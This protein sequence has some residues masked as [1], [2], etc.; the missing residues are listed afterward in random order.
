MIDGMA[1]L[2]NMVEKNL[3]SP[4]FLVGLID[5]WPGLA[6]LAKLDGRVIAASRKWEAATGVSKDEL[7][8]YGWKHFVLAEDQGKV[9]EFSTELAMGNPP[10]QSFCYR[11][12]HKGKVYAL[13]WNSTVAVGADQDVTF[14]TAELVSVDNIPTT[15]SE[16]TTQPSL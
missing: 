11:W 16:G 12:V 13:R 15:S 8:R 2:T 1:T 9:A 10:P 5:H 4:A 3:E 6:I 14:A 7:L